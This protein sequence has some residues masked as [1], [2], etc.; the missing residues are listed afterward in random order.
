VVTVEGL[1]LASELVEDADALTSAISVGELLALLSSIARDPD[2]RGC[3]TALRL[4]SELLLGPIVRAQRRREE[5]DTGADG[6]GVVVV[7]LPANAAVPDQGALLE[8]D[9]IDVEVLG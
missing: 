6:R 2:H 3:P 5:L 1:G 9:A 4:L 8:G 7:R